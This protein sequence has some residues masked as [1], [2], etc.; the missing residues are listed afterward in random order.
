MWL[1]AIRIQLGQLQ[2]N[3]EPASSS[4]VL[5]G[6]TQYREIQYFTAAQM[7]QSLSVTVRSRTDNR[8]F[9][10]NKTLVPVSDGHVMTSPRLQV[11]LTTM[12]SNQQ[13]FSQ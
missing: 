13:Q 8:I 11:K 1:D 9:L 6:L 7:E 10:Y 2:K 12:L 4:W 5:A 3:G